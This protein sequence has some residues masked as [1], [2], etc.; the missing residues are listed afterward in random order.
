MPVMGAHLI[1]TTMALG[2]T[3]SPPGGRPLGQERV[4]ERRH[5]YGIWLDPGALL[6]TNPSPLFPLPASGSRHCPHLSRQLLKEF[7]RRLSS[8]QRPAS[9]QPRA[10]PWVRMRFVLAPGQRPGSSPDESRLQRWE[11]SFGRAT[12]GVALGWYE[13]RL[14]RREQDWRF[15]GSS[16]RHSEGPVIRS[17]KR[18]G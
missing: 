10:T 15:R 9:Y 16:D 7:H 1:T 12:Q 4:G 2:V 17:L 6:R 8:G 13:R 14:W 18:C 3:P 5:H 11:R